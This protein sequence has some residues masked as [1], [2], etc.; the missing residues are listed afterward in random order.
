MFIHEQAG[1]LH[2]ILGILI[3]VY[4]GSHQLPLA[5]AMIFYNQP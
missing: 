1:T 5:N 3:K 4:F 2:L